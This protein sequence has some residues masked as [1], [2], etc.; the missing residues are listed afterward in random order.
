MTKMSRKE[1]LR[2]AEETAGISFWVDL[3]KGRLSKYTIQ[4]KVRR[5]LVALFRYVILICVGFVVMTHLCTLAKDALTDPNVLADK[6]TMWIPQKVSTLFMEMALSRNLMDFWKSLG[7]TMVMTIALTFL[8]V[9]SAG[10]AAYS[11][12]RLKF[13]GSNILFFF[14]VLTIVVPPDAIML[15][16]YSAFR[17]FDIFGIIKAV[18]GKPLNLLN[19]PVS[20]FILAGLGMGVRSGLY[21]YFLRQGIRGLPISV[22]EAAHVDGAGFLTTFFRIVMP[23]M[24]GSILTVSVLSFL[25]NYTDTYYSSLLN[26]SQYNLAYHYSALQSNIRWSID[27]AAKSNSAWLSQIDPS[28]PYVQT[29]VISACSLLVVLPLI[30]L[31]CFV[32][33]RFVQGA[34]RSGLGGD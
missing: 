11:F 14:V 23:S 13:K 21:I 15:A 1:R 31:Y 24:S 20:Q 29:A 10:L 19:K 4:K 5:F 28:N 8:Q 34:A 26:P 27:T 9:L 17:N 32:Q 12:A 18:T 2:M 7:Y 6:S 30:I 3:K 16:Q 22:E 25:W 33:K